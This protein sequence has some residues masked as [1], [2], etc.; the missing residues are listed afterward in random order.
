MDNA[1]CGLGRESKDAE[2]IVMRFAQEG[3]NS[4]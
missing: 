4:R 3:L 2:M 1:C